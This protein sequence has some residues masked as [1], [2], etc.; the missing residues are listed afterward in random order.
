MARKLT[1]SRLAVK[2]VLILVWILLSIYST[3]ILVGKLAQEYFLKEENV[4][5]FSNSFTNNSSNT[6]TSLELNIISE[7]L[8]FILLF[9]GNRLFFHVKIKIATRRF[10]WGLIYV[11]PLGIFLIGNVIQAFNTLINKQIDQNEIILALVFS[12][13]VGIA[14]EFAFRGLILG[15][16][17]TY[18]KK[19]L[20]YYFSA[21]LIQGFFFGGL[22]LVNLD[23]QTFS[24]TFTQIIYASA[25]GIIFGVVYEKS[26]SI[27]I[28]ILAHALIDGLAFIADPT[29]VMKKSLETLPSSTYVVM[30]GILLFIIAYE[31]LTILLANKAKMDKIWQ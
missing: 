31:A 4:N 3:S 18:H 24:V 20:F 8:F 29:A 16:L 26:G 27:V 13:I 10:A 9:L 12:V 15:N 14:E 23:R 6:T 19:S 2:T 22:H 28:T 25:I 11:L 17:L 1:K 5:I 30:A 7:S 21:I